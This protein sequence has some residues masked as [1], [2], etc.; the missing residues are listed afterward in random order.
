MLTKYSSQ[1]VAWVDLE[2]PTEEEIRKI[3]EEYSV[4]PIVARELIS[5]SFRSRVDLYGNLI[6][7]ILHFPRTRDN[8][9]GEDKR[10]NEIDF[11]IGKKFIITARYSPIEALHK[12]SRLF[13]MNSLLEKSDDR[14]AGHLFFRMMR[15][16]YGSLLHEIDSVRGS[17][18]EVE[19]KIF[20]GREREMVVEISKISR[21]ILDFKSAFGLHAEVL[22]S[23]EVAGKKF[24]GQDFDYELHAIIGEYAKIENALRANSEFAGEL[25]DT[26]DSLLSSKQNEIMKTITIIAFIFL[27]FSIIG[28]FF[29]MNTE[30]TPLIGLPYDWLIAVGIMVSAAFTLFVVAKMKRWL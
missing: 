11:V 28:S 13:E 19:S 10:D 25:R 5:P 3:M 30:S 20:K 4:N 14:H 29:Q 26:N 21:I 12:V 23:F 15:E 17:I 27:P 22:E 9:K 1:S 2:N 16:I 18:R 6:Y 24:F 7:L 8:G